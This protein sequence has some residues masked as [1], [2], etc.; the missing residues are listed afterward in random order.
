LHAADQTQTS[1]HRA[2]RSCICNNIRGGRLAACEAG[3]AEW[4]PLWNQLFPGTNSARRGAWTH[5][6]DCLSGLGRP[7]RGTPQRPI[8]PRSLRDVRGIPVRMH[9]YNY[10]FVSCHPRHM[11]DSSR[12]DMLFSSG[13]SPKSLSDPFGGWGQRGTR[14]VAVV[15]AILCGSQQM[16]NL[17]LPCFS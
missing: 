17:R 11:A 4:P 2:R 10:N 14:R 8:E 6:V 16:N 9:D 1:R 3:V 12:N 5:F 15:V 7:K 13:D